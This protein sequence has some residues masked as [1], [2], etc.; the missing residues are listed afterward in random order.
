MLYEVITV[1][2]LGFK[3]V[4]MAAGGDAK[5]H[6]LELAFDGKTLAGALQ[7]KGGLNAK[8][9]Q[10]ALSEAWFDTQLGRWQLAAPLTI[11]SRA[12]WQKVQ[13]GEQCWRSEPA[14]LCISAADLAASQGKLGLRLD[15]ITSY[16]VCY[17]KLLR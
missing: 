16:N 9:W 15:R 14:S 10:G 4:R 3:N 5:S 13:L 2:G 7:L 6:R 17:T 12:P 8:G 1:A 11:A